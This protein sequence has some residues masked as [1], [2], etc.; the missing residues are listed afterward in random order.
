MIPDTSTH[1]RS[2]RR[3]AQTPSRRTLLPAARATA[4]SG[5]PKDQPAPR[6]AGH[7]VRNVA[8]DLLRQRLLAQHLASSTALLPVSALRRAA[9]DATALAGAT[10]FGLLLLPALLDEQVEAAQRYTER[11]ADIRRRSFLLLRQ[12]TRQ[13]PNPPTQTRPS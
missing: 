1:G 12:D 7:P 11:A 13:T 9:N 8:L 3:G 2:R 4:R 6:P 5:R 10:G